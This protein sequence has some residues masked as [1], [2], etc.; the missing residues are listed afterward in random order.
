M[1]F[2]MEKLEILEEKI[3][4]VSKLIETLRG[5]NIKI[6]TE[7]E[8]VKQENELLLSENRS[9]RRLMAEIDHLREERKLVKSKCEK[10]LAHY[11]KMN[12]C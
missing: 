5:K 9:V 1:G 4:S 7:L 11:D 2:G 3:Q 10:L 12:L 6:E 8:T